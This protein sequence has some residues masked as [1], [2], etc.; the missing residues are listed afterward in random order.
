MNK[1]THWHCVYELNYHLVLVTKYRKRCL[2][3]KILDYLK[4]VFENLCEKW[5][6]ELSEFNGEADHVHLLLKTHPST[7]MS[8]L[9]NN[10]KTVSSRLLRRDF[11][12]HLSKYYYKSVLWTRAYYLATTGGASVDTIRK[13]IENQGKEKEQ[14]IST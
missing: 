6:I 12:N 11:E 10:L 1:K 13:Y 2:S 7:T 3:P 5:E 9:I 4:N 8:K 14:F